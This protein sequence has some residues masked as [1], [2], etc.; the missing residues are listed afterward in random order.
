[1]GAKN[2]S[3]EDAN[4]LIRQKF[5]IQQLHYQASN[6]YDS[7]TTKMTREAC[8]NRRNSFSR[9]KDTVWKQTIT[10]NEA[11]AVSWRAWRDLNPQPS[12]SKVA[13]IHNQ[14]NQHGGKALKERLSPFPFSSQ[15]GS[16]HI[17]VETGMETMKPV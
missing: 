6:N 10:T 11:V 14:I 2:E 5:D 12:D 13:Q 1:M 7:F 16:F 9:L 15:F 17:S 8:T 3:Y 4:I